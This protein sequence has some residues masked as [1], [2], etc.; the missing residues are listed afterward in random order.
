MRTADNSFYENEVRYLVTSVDTRFEETDTGLYFA[1]HRL[2]QELTPLIGT[3]VASGSD[4]ALERLQ[5][6]ISQDLGFLSRMASDL[7]VH[8]DVELSRGGASQELADELRKRITGG[9]AITF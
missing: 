4:I 7:A 6:G 2:E 1:F 8:L 9:L 5:V 3:Q